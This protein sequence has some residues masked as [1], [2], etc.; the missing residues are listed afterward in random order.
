MLAFNP[1]YLLTTLPTLVTGAYLMWLLRRAAEQK[2]NEDLV[3]A[4]IV[5][6]EG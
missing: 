1:I 3:P 6:E 5:I 4:P 2:A